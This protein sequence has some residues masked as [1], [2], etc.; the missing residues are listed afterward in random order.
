M[1]RPLKENSRRI[2]TL[3]ATALVCFNVAMLE[4]CSK[5]DDE[6]AATAPY[7][8]IQAQ[9]VQSSIASAQP[10]P[11]GT[12][13]DQVAAASS[14]PTATAA[15]SADSPQMNQPTS[16]GAPT[17]AASTGMARMLGQPPM[18]GA[19]TPTGG[20][21]PAIGAPHIYH[22]GADTF[23]VDQASAIGLTPD[24]QKRLTSLKENAGSAF[25]TTQRKIDQGEQDV[26]ALS[27]SETPDIAKIETK[28]GEISRLTAQQRIE[29]IRAVGVA[30]GV[31]TDTQRKAVAA[32][33]TPM[34]PGTMAPAPSASGMNMGAAPSSSGMPMSAPTKMPKGMKMGGMGDAG[35]SGGMGHM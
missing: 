33:G 10:A 4:G 16:I 7:P 14:A 12:K 27:S 28:I 22:L 20:L 11:L 19:A 23:F 5:A 18:T 13:Q 29:F 15:P 34:Q 1:N 21:P 3:A 32:Q 30:V 25:A 31:L 6:T 8:T 24:Q 9:A 17:G 26:W 35:S 2:H